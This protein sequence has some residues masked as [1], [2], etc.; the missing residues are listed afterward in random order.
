MQT[1]LAA[2][3]GNRRGVGR[4]GWGGLAPFGGAAFPWTR[5]LTSASSRPTAGSERQPARRG[6]SRA[7]RRDR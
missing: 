1:V 2:G 6:P 4:R 3:G 7:L 5:T